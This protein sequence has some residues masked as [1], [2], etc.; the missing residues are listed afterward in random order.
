MVQ[1][2]LLSCMKNTC[3]SFGRLASCSPG[4]YRAAMKH[5]QSQKEQSVTKLLLK[6][7][8]ERQ[9]AESQKIPEV[10]I[11]SEPL[12]PSDLFQDDGS[13]YNLNF[14]FP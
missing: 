8:I 1:P 4:C 12:A 7:L 9:K 5:K 10:S 13:G 2:Q 14:T 6:D 3:L 11:G